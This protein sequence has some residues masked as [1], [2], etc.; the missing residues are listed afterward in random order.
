MANVGIHFKWS[1]REF[2]NFVPFI[3]KAVW[4]NDVLRKGILQ[5]S[6]NAD[7]V[8]DLVQL[9]CLLIILQRDVGAVLFRHLKTN[10]TKCR[11]VNFAKLKIL[12]FLR[13][14]Q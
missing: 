8:A 1:G 5:L 9:C 6:F 3:E 10:L 7:R 12:Y 11:E 2:H 13:I 4:V 14:W